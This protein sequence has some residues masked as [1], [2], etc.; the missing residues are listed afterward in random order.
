MPQKRFDFAR[1]A[2]GKTGDNEAE[3]IELIVGWYHQHLE[4]RAAFISRE[5]LPAV[6]TEL[7]VHDGRACCVCYG[8]A[9]AVATNRLE[10]RQCPIHARNCEHWQ[11]IRATMLP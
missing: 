2:L 4:V 6:Q 9:D 1:Q 10:V 3:A 7:R 8:D 11:A 5:L